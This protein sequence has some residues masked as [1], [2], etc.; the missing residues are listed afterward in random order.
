[1]MENFLLQVNLYPVP[2]SPLSPRGRPYR[3]KMV[4]SFSALSYL[5]KGLETGM[6][7]MKLH[8][9]KMQS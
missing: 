3:Q 1:M 2:S 6:C 9:A 5:R 7:P 4:Q 8:D